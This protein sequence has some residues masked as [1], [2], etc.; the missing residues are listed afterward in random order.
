MPKTLRNTGYYIKPRWTC[1]ACYQDFEAEE[2]EDYTCSCGAKIATMVEMVP[3]FITT[4]I[5]DEDDDR[6]R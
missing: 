4:V 1:P 6:W 3:S 5:E 2:G